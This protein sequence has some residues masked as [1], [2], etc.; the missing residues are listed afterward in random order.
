ML[1]ELEEF[2]AYTEQPVYTTTGKRDNSFLGRFT[3]DMI[4]D[5]EG[6]SRVLTIFARGYLF[7]ND[8][9]PY[10][11]IELARRALC[12]WCS[13]PE[14]SDGNKKDNP[15][16]SWQFTTDFREYNTEFPE[17]VDETG[18]G[19]FYRHVHAVADFMQNSP[20]KVSKTAL[21]KA[22]PINTGFDS[23]WRK[24]VM[25]FQVPISSPETK[26]AWVLRFDDIL[27][28]ALELG[29]LRKQEVAFSSDDMQ[30][31]EA[32]TPEGVP[33]EVISILI[34]YYNANKPA[35]SD[36]VVLPVTNFD[37]YFG[38]TNFSRKWLNQIPPEIMERQKQSFGICRYQMKVLATRKRLCEPFPCIK[39]DGFLTQ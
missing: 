26:G 28:D 30:I 17:I 20:G 12:A 31:I 29:A 1:N 4:M 21:D 37:A 27:A 18:G 23:A 36:W 11:R 34:A 39:N 16:A 8:E 14:R 5:F 25:Q 33:A 6:L 2:C 7:Q 15:K 10:D 13:V 9:N 3:F 32:I 22:E 24:K 38:N 35:D 19:W